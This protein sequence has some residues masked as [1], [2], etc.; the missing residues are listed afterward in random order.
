MVQFLKKDSGTVRGKFS[1]P[2]KQSRDEYLTLELNISSEHLSHEINKSNRKKNSYF[3]KQ[4]P[5]LKIFFHY[6]FKNNI[7]FFGRKFTDVAFALELFYS[8]RYCPQN[9]A[10]YSPNF[11]I[12]FCQTLKCCLLFCRNN[13]WWFPLRQPHCRAHTYDPNVGDRFNGFS[14][15]NEIKSHLSNAQSYLWSR[16]TTKSGGDTI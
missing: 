14:L 3:M 5:P 6:L 8:Q 4:F 15:L 7:S 13:F 11:S 2:K 10:S 1:L 12:N 9:A 16:H